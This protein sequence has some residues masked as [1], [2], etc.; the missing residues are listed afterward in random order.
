MVITTLMMA[1]V[2][3]HILQLNLYVTADIFIVTMITGWSRFQFVFNQF[4]KTNLITT[5]LNI[6]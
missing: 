4:I 5:L 2:K 1:V 6:E 3:I